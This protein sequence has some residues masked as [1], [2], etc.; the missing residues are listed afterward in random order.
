M[1]LAKV[2]KMN[3]WCWRWDFS[4]PSESRPMRQEKEE[5]RLGEENEK[6]SFEWTKHVLLNHWSPFKLLSRNGSNSSG[7]LANKQWEV[8]DKTQGHLPASRDP[9][10]KTEGLLE[11]P[12][13]RIWH[14]LMA[15][16]TSKNLIFII[17]CHL[18]VD[19]QKG[20]VGEGT[21]SRG[22]AFKSLLFL[23]G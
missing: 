2:A 4:R 10:P 7:E 6:G 5:V 3:V 16:P 15:N 11:A 8:W 14:V 9:P 22:G 12:H 23:S 13:A 19:S 21:G 17:V 20:C 18:L 1:C